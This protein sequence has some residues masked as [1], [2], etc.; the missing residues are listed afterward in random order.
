MSATESL[1]LRILSKA[2]QRNATDIHF[3]PL[4]TK[5]DIYFRIHG[6]RLLFDSITTSQ[7]DLIL[8]YYKFTS[9]MDIGEIRKP[10]NGTIPFHKNSHHFSLR[11]STLPVNH[12]ES[13]AIRILPQDQALTLDQLFLFQNQL[14]TLKKWMKHKS[15]LILLSGP[16][17]SG[18]T[19]TLYALLEEFIKEESYQTITLEDPIEKNI[20]DILQVQVNEKAGITYQSGLKAALRHDPDIIM[21]G[22]IRDRHTAQF[23]FEASLTG[24]LVLSTIHAKHAAGTIHRLFEMGLSATELNQ[25][26]IGVAS[27]ELLPIVTNNDNKRRAAILEILDGRILEAVINQ[28]H[29]SITN[30]QSFHY[31]R[32]KAYCYGFISKATYE[33]LE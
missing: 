30:K 5:T 29:S 2:V 27:I 4:E 16:T 3:Y 23:A 17:G 24:H 6:K 1:S 20:Q 31:L 11:L 9:G 13:L 33:N 26:L 19:T 22:E 10:Q 32:R 15:G 28:Q 12:S 14:I 25:S 7:Y 18:K 21:V 8:T